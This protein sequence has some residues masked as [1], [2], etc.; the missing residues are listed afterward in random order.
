[1]LAAGL[2]SPRPPLSWGLR[3]QPPARGA[4]PPWTPRWGCS[5]AC[6]SCG[7]FF[8]CLG[9]CDSQT[10]FFCGFFSG[11]LGNPQRGIQGAE[12]PWRGSGGGAPSLRGVWGAEPPK[13]EKANAKNAIISILIF[14]TK[15]GFDRCNPHQNDARNANLASESPFHGVLRHQHDENTAVV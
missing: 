5:N 2:K 9:N 1:M 15:I 13:Q 4:P 7:S 11:I 12:P 6:G 8:S 3:P 14:F 10:F